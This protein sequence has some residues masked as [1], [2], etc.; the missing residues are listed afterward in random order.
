[1][2]MC[3]GC[4]TTHGEHVGGLCKACK[5]KTKR[6]LYE[7][8]TTLRAEVAEAVS[9]AKSESESAEEAETERG[10]I[11]K[12]NEHLADAVSDAAEFIRPFAEEILPLDCSWEQHTRYSD[13]RMFLSDLDGCEYY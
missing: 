6:D 11:E 1:M 12:A 7:Q 3:A 13:A 8:I 5:R 4:E 10:K 2:S 9:N